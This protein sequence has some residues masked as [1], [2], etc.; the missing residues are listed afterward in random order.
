MTR[1]K[2]FVFIIVISCVVLCSMTFSSQEK[3]AI[4]E[5]AYST[6]HLQQDFRILRNALE[7][8]HAGLYRYTSKTELDEHFESIEK[9]LDRS[10]TEL[11][12]YLMLAP[13]IAH[14]HDGHTSISLSHSL[15][16]SLSSE[17]NIFPFSLRFINK[18]TYLFRSC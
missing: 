4:I 12:F 6:K 1:K 7:E 14:I 13:L 5:K 2:C 17:Y 16:L 11:D 18:K 15:E 9:E 10:M 8:G 3:T